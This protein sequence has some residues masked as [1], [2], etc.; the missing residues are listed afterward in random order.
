M[1]KRIIWHM[2]CR[3]LCFALLLAALVVALDKALFDENSVLPV[4]R[5]I[6]SGHIEPVDILLVG[7]SHSYVSINNHV[8]GQALGKNAQHLRCSS[9]NG[10]IVAAMLEAYLHYQVPELVILECNPF[11]VN[12]YEIMRNE[13]RG[14]VYQ[15]FDGIPDYW[16]RAK[17]LS[18]V[19]DAE[20]VPAGVFHLLRPTDMWSRWQKG[21]SEPVDGYEPRHYFS[22][23][24]NYD[25]D[26]LEAYYWIPEEQPVQSSLFDANQQAINRI[27]QLAKEKDFE[28]WLVVAPVAHYADGYQQDMRRLYALGENCDRVTLF[29]NSMQ[30]LKQIGLT[31]HDFSD[32]GHLCC[33]GAEKYTQHLVRLLAQHYNIAPDYSRV[34]A[35]RNETVMVSEDTLQLQM[36]CYGDALYSFQYTDTDGTFIKT[37]FSKENMLTLPTDIAPETVTVEMKL[38]NAAEDKIISYSF[39]DEEKQ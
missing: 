32:A 25:A 17:A 35:Y 7:N 22:V 24:Q 8:I 6:R 18:A 5:N 3:L 10:G 2:L 12:N 19:M 31:A 20:H 15:S 11:M 23:Q 21:N 34:L 30:Q 28:V 9:A 38:D 4:W 27:L 13:L 29:D 37:A 33:R 14:I 26:A 16:Q 1:Q 36:E 39:M